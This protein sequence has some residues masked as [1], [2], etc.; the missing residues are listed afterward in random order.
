MKHIFIVSCLVLM[1]LRQ[2]HFL[3]I[4]ILAMFSKLSR[5]SWNLLLQAFIIFPCMYLAIICSSC[6]QALGLVEDA[7]YENQHCLSKIVEKTGRIQYNCLF[8]LLFVWIHIRNR[9]T[10]SLRKTNLVL[11]IFKTNSVQILF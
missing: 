8:Y 6:W 11:H 5:K 9:K 1:L 4:Q 7:R 10:F 3:T 2:W